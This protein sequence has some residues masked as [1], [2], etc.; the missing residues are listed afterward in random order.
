VTFTARE[1]PACEYQKPEFRQVAEDYWWQA[2]F[3]SVPADRLPALAGRYN[4][5]KVPTVLLFRNGRPVG[6]PLVGAYRAE[7]YRQA[8]RAILQGRTF[9][10]R[11]RKENAMSDRPKAIT[12]K[13]DPL[14]LTGQEVEVGQAA[15]DFTAL[16]TDLSPAKLSDYNGKTVVLASVPSLDTSV[17]ATETRRFNEE[18]ARFGDDVVVLTLSMD[19]PFA[20]AR[21]CGNEG[22]DN[23]ETL[24]DHRDASFGQAY[25]VLIK[26]L[27]LL[28]RAVF[29]VASD[30][31]LAYKQ[32][33][34]EVTDEPDYDDVI[35][36]VGKA[37]G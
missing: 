29:V 18:A 8:I 31:K 19:L 23:V 13:G 22:I 34:S 10:T 30:G 16:K 9:I 1:C 25:G 35:Q 26:E 37:R 27:R 28:A 21:W 2:D 15:P 3:A 17:C 6:E 33:V 12:M 11:P 14:T 5:R 7:T 36:A 32:L 24:S 20:Q 4:I